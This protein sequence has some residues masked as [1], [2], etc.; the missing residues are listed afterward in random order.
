MSSAETRGEFWGAAVEDWIKLFE[1]F[2][3][4][5]WTGMLDV[6]VKERVLSP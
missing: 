1:P 6:E 5:I 2:N 4:S 3:K